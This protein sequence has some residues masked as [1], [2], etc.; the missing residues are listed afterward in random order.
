MK[1]LSLS[2]FEGELIRTSTMVFLATLS[3][4]LIV[5]LANL[6]FLNQLTPENFAALKAALYL[7]TFLPVV[8]EFGVGMTLTKYIA[9]F[10]DDKEKIGYLIRWFL[11]LKVFS[12][13]IL[14][15]LIFILK[16]QIASFIFRDVSLIFPGIILIGLSFFNVFQFI[17]LGYQRFKLFALSQ[18]LTLTISSFLSVLLIPLGTFYMILGWGFGPLIG[19]LFAVK[20]FFDKNILK[21]HKE[22]DV[23]KIFLKFSIPI[24]F[25][26]IPT[27]LF[28]IVVPLF[29]LFFSQ[30]LISYLSF[31]LI[32]YSAA[33][34]IPGALATIIF[35][36]VSE[37]NGLKR[38]VD[39]KNLLKKA[40][41]LYSFVVF[42]GTVFVIFLSDW[43]IMFFENYLP[44]LFMFK[45]L[46]SLGLIFGYNSIYSNYLQGLGKIKRFALFT[47]TQNILL[48]IISFALLNSMV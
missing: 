31:A 44:S 41:G 34:L 5:F 3:A 42:V 28:S 10:R 4:N 39:A 6:F 23:K 33:L 16:E 37:L 43:F 26:S 20:F 38:H 25:I 17:A 40:F 18:F 46:V 14:L 47:L 7:F 24:Y 22:F 8:I 29:S 11:K 36:K 45:V 1:K 21:K 15:F 12:Y 19:N 2:F 48:I 9:E 30:K 13:L 27:A 32:F 35:P